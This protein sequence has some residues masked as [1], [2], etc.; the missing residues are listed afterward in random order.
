MSEKYKNINVGKDLISEWVKGTSQNLMLDKPIKALPSTH[1]RVKGK[2]VPVNK[3]ISDY[4]KSM[5]ML[6]KSVKELEDTI[7]KSDKKLK[8]IKLISESKVI[9]KKYKGRI[10]SSTTDMI[11]AVRLEAAGKISYSRLL[12][13][14]SWSR[15]PKGIIEVSRMIAG[16][17]RFTGL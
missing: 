8:E 13:I 17:G 7:E 1:K 11:N 4:L 5:G 9:K 16:I 10:Y 2:D 12:E 6:E 3:Q 15:D 14:A